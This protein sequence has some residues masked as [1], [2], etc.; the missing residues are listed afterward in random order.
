VAVAVTAA[1]DGMLGTR[2]LIARRGLA[3][4]MGTRSIGHLDPGAVSCY[5]LIRAMIEGE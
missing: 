4:R 2:P 3:L 5:L 1:R